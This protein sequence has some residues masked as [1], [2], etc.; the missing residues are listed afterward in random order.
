MDSLL[1]A[2]EGRRY[3]AIFLRSLSFIIMK[4]VTTH[5]LVSH[6]SFICFLNSKK[7]ILKLHTHIIYNCWKYSNNL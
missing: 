2:Q 7:I 3:V 4:N 5:P 1:Y 6:F